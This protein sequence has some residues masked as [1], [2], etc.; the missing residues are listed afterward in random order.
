MKI[1]FNYFTSLIAL[2][3]LFSFESNAQNTRSFFSVTGGY[4]LPVGELAREKLDDPFAGLTGSG[5][6]GQANYDFRVARWIGLRASGSMNINKTNSQPILDKANSYAQILNESFTWQ[7]KVSNWKLNALMVGPALYINMNRVQLELH[8]QAG[9]VWANSPT[10][11]LVGTSEA[12]G[13]PINVSLKKAS[14]SAFGLAGGASLRLPLSGALFFQLSG[15]VIGA[16]AEIKDVTI[17]AVRGS[18]DFSEQVSEK[19]FIGVVNV[20]AGF[21]FAF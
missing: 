5:Y 2:I 15:D 18:F 11:D 21:G 17:R 8:A 3:L 16:E 12:G 4:S 9:K 10:V 13:A 20:G 1:S 19:R 7:S 14:T 6:F